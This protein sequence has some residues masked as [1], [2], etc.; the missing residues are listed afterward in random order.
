MFSIVIAFGIFIFSWNSQNFIQSYYFLFIG[1]AFLFIGFS[2][3]IGHIFK[4][5][6]FYLL[7]LAVIQTGLRNPYDLLLRQ[8]RINEM[9]IEQERDKARKYFDI[10]GAMMIIINKNGNV[11][12]I[13]K[14]G[15]ETLKFR[16]EEIIGK[17]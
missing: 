15:C 17:N 13:N 11:E 7:Y 10:A 12:L 4:I 8:N 9:H 14:K 5:A 16:K 3:F 6:S 2:N 1:I